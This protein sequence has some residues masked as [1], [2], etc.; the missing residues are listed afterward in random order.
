MGLLSF[1]SKAPSADEVYDDL[2]HKIVL[3]TLL[4]RKE[5]KTDN[6]QL[7]TDA[8]AEL[9]YL[10]IHF[11][12][13]IVS[14]MFDSNRGDTIYNE[15]SKRAITHY[16]QSNL[17]PNTPQDVVKSIIIKMM[18]DLNNRQEI[19]AKCDSIYGDIFPGKGTMVFALS[20]YIHRALGMTDREDV[21][22]ILCGN[23]NLEEADLNDFPDN[24]QIMEL[25]IH[26]SAIV[27]TLKFKDSLSKLT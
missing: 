21:D 23:R 10:L 3:S 12:D 9:M 6:N 27:P 22:D 14:Q 8:A 26:V 13:R 16:I 15:V 1:F 20:F 2:G 11:L 17:K 18:S 24:D 19:Y 5:L 4:F 7:S 25:S